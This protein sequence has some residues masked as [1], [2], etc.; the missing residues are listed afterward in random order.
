VSLVV[1]V[2][3]C[4][5]DQQYHQVIRDTWGKDIAALGVNILFFVGG[6]AT[7]QQLDEVHVD[8][9][10]DYMSLPYKVKEICRWFIKQPVDHIFLCDNDTYVFSNKFMQCRFENYDYTGRFLFQPDK[11]IRYNAKT[12]TK[13]D[14]IHERCYSFAAGGDGYFLSKKAAAAVASG[15][16][17]SWAE[18]L[19][20]GQIL[21]P[22]IA[23]GQMT[24]K[25]TSFKEYSIHHFDD[26]Q[27]RHLEWSNVRDWVLKIYNE[28]LL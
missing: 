20:V 4:Q 11:V 8:C 1:A 25:N 2:K 19:C 28:R 18:D 14:E 27:S 22:E 15:D 24:L 9:L 3:S 17:V 21:G 23:K 10:D 12:P 16:L 7:P 5:R 26:M 6:K 13:Q